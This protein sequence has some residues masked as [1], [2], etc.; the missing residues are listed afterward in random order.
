MC[1]K[2]PGIWTSEDI[3]QL[4][5]VGNIS[6]FECLIFVGCVCVSIWDHPTKFVASLCQNNV[7]N[8][9]EKLGKIQ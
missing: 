6:K 5:I 1:T 8:N 3:G 7:H 2:C 4:I 9:E